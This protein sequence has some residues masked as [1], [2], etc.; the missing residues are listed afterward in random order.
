MLDRYTSRMQRLAYAGAVDLS[1]EVVPADDDDGDDET[2]HVLMGPGDVKVVSLDRLND[3][4]RWDLINDRTYVWKPG[5]AAW[6]QLFV[7]IGPTQEPPPEEEPPWSVAVA[8]GEIKT[9]S[10][11]QLDDWYRL[12]LIDDR[13]LVWKPGMT[14]WQPLGV[15]AGIETEPPRAS[16]SAGLPSAPKPAPAVSVVPRP[17]QVASVAPRSAQ[18]A[19]VAPRSAQ[20]ASFVPSSAPVAFTLPAPAKRAGGAERW[21]LGAALAAGLVTTLYR[22]DVMTELARSV[23]QEPAFERLGQRLGGPGFGTLGGVEALLESSGLKLA[24][25]RVPELLVAQEVSH[26]QAGRAAA[27]DSQAVSSAEPTSAATPETRSPSGTTTPEAAPRSK[28]EGLGSVVAPTSTHARGKRTKPDRP[29][30]DDIVTRR[31]SRGRG[32]EY[33]PLNPKL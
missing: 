18:V 13:T 6:Q 27:S 15:V 31:A 19:S 26:V 14:S 1:D 3:L 7:V 30:A 4:Y 28:A 22:N 20:V 11:E 25:V 9:L 16:A 8:P 17:A 29:A 32:T 24:E 33:D 23:H 10:L 21:L 5:M 2:W 12:D